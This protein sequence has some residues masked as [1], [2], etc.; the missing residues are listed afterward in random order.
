MSIASNYEKMVQA[1]ADEAKKAHRNP[2]EI[3]LVAVSKTHPWEDVN[4]AYE[5]GCRIFGE[6]R[7]QEALE[8]KAQAPSD[9]A[10]HLIGTLQK[11][12]VNKVVGEFA[13]IHSV[14]TF[15]LAEKLS[16]VSKQKGFTT[17]ILLQVNV[18]GEESKHGFTAQTVKEAFSKLMALPHLKIEGLMTMAPFTEDK[19]VCVSCFRNLRLLRDELGLKELSMGMSNDWRE[20]IQEGATFLRIGSAVFG[21]R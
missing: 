21:N 8:K 19:N 12:K 17:S 7:V 3:K 14:D 20:A 18:S 2:S 13:L 16:E 5:A 4:Q 10:W 11:N 15:E 1:I 9:T 6:N